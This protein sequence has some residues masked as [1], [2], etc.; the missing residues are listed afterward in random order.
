KAYFSTADSAFTPQLDDLTMGAAAF[1]TSAQTINPA[2]ASYFTVTSSTPTPTAGTSFNVTI[3]AKDQF[4]NTATGYSAAGKTFAWSGPGNAPDTTAP[5][6]PN[7]VTVVGAFSG[8]VA[9]VSVTLYKAEAVSLDIS[10]GTTIN[11]FGNIAYDAD[12][13]VGGAAAVK[14]V[15]T[16]QPASTATAGVDLT[17]QPAVQVQDTYGNPINSAVNP[18]TL[19]A[20]LASDGTPGGGTLSATTTNPLA[21][22]GTSGTAS[23]AGMDYTKAE[24]IKLKATA[25]GL[26]EVLS[27]AITVTPSSTVSAVNSLVGATTPIVVS[28]GASASTITVTAKD[29]YNNVIPGIAAA[30]V[31]LASTGTGNT[32]TPP[33]AATNAGGVTTGT[34]SSTDPEAKTVSVTINGTAITQTT[35]VN[36][37]GIKITAPT[38]GTVWGAGDMD[39]NITWATHGLSDRIQIEYNDG[40]G[41]QTVFDGASAAIYTG[42]AKVSPQLWDIPVN[43]T[44]SSAYKVRITDGGADG[45]LATTTDNVVV[46]SSPFGV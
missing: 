14:L 20:V 26:I 31:V 41:W 39:R 2:G 37:N 35:T 3:T 42:S 23:F 36:V 10:D 46:E 45:N 19:A 33:S 44:I 24:S 6:Y 18:I 5:F 30:N 11:S 1:D 25:T 32:V 8:G 4:G 43:A 13:T 22:N 27:T 17:T 7:N 29:A 21:A 9:T 40:S 38:T 12:V 28:S 34:L 15:F 16:T